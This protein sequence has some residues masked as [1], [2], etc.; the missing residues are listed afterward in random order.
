MPDSSFNNSQFLRFYCVSGSKLKYGYGALIEWDW[1]G[2]LKDF[3]KN[4]L[5]C[6]FAHN[7]TH[8]DC[9]V[10]VIRNQL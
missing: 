8:I 4:L 7:K 9:S 5:H 3:E 2:K 6:H 1:Q 10:C